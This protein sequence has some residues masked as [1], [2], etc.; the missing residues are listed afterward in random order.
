MYPVNLHVPSIL[1]TEHIL[2]QSKNHQRTYSALEG[3]SQPH[4]SAS[5]L[6]VEVSVFYCSPCFLYKGNMRRCIICERRKEAHSSRLSVLSHQYSYLWD[7]NVA[8]DWYTK[9]TLT[10]LQLMYKD[11]LFTENKPVLHHN[12]CDAEYLEE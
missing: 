6:L 9:N 4:W 7:H 5:M 12:K 2:T 1:S 10:L 3:T 11:F 8:D